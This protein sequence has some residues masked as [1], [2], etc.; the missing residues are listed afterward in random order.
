M[1][2]SDQLRYERK[3][4]NQRQNKLH[5]YAIVLKKLNYFL[6]N[7]TSFWFHKAGSEVV[8]PSV[9]GRICDEYFRN[10]IHAPCVGLLVGVPVGWTCSVPSQL[11]LQYIELFLQFSNF[12]IPRRKQW[13]GKINF[14][15]F[16]VVGAKQPW[17]RSAIWKDVDILT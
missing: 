16:L 5:L 1:M 8:S 6:R 13:L 11:Y 2:R 9:N 12:F 14:V 17:V 10:I 4:W 7:D 3:W 15:N